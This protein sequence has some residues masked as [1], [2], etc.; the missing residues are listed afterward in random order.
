MNIDLKSRQLEKGRMMK[1]FN[2]KVKLL[3]NE[4]DKTRNLTQMIDSK[5]A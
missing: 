5:L 1:E 3:K 2:E 4:N